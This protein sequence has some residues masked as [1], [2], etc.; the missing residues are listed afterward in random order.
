MVFLWENFRLHLVCAISWINQWMVSSRAR[1]YLYYNY[2]CCCQQLPKG[3]H[4]I[5]H[6]LNF[7]NLQT[8]GF[9]FKHS[10]WEMLLLHVDGF[11]I[12]SKLPKFI[13]GTVGVGWKGCKKHAV[14]MC[15]QS[16]RKKF[17]Y[18]SHNQSQAG[19]AGGGRTCHRQGGG[20]KEPSPKQEWFFFL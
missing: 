10:F 3:Q 17:I 5:Q 16:F 20:A 8:C 6:K 2:C 19:E 9:Y 4:L 18:V 1:C 13:C 7:I 14:D 15:F 11:I 12:D